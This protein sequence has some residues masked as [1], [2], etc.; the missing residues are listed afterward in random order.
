[1]HSVVEGLVT[2]GTLVVVASIVYQAVKNPAGSV[3]L[4]QATTGGA[5]D[6]VSVLYK[7]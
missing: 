1:M 4:V 2:I 5:T 7:G 6:F 3:P